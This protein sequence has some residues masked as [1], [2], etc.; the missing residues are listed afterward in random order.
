MMDMRSIRGPGAGQFKEISMCACCGMTSA[1]RWGM[2]KG[3][4][5]KQ[6]EA[7]MPTFTWD[8]VHLRSPDPEQTAQWFE[9]M[10]GAEVIRS[11]QDGK[12]RID[13]RLGGASI[14]IAP[15]APGDGVNPPPTA[16]YQGLDHFAFFVPDLDKVVAGLK[17]KGAEFTKDLQVPRPGIRICFLRGPQGIS[18]ELLERNPKFV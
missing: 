14:F 12:P 5:R 13:L 3:E 1:A 7:T 4:P 6:G 2:N 15:V 16:P 11:T 8:H 18:I 10:L 17:A 9:R